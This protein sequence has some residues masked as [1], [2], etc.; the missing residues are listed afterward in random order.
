MTTLLKS[1][2]RFV[3]TAH[4]L[5]QAVLQ[6]DGEAAAAQVGRVRVP[7]LGGG[8]ADQLLALMGFDQALHLARQRPALG[9]IDPVPGLV[10][11]RLWRGLRVVAVQAAAR[12]VVQRA[13]GVGQGRRL[14]WI[15]VWRERD[16]AD[17]PLA[18][19]G[20]RVGQ[21]E[22]RAHAA[23]A[24]NRQGGNQGAERRAKCR[25]GGRQWHGCGVWPDDTLG[26]IHPATQ[27][28]T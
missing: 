2:Q 7:G 11:D 14:A 16:D 1:A 8:H 5:E 23:A 25:L 10:L 18:V 9:L 22:V 4:G 13:V 15:E 6:A 3:V 28:S 27:P 21:P 12:P 26:R 24:C 19:Q 20:R 17:L